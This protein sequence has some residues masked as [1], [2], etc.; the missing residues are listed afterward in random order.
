MDHMGLSLAAHRSQH[1]SNLD[2]KTCDHI[3]CMTSSHAAYIRSMGVAPQQISVVNAEFGGVPDPF[4]G[5][6]ADYINC[7]QVLKQAAQH[8]VAELIGPDKAVTT[9]ISAIDKAIDNAIA[10]L[11]TAHAAEPS[12]PSGKPSELV[13]ANHISKWV[14]RLVPMPSIALQLAARGQH[15]ERW[16]IAR[17]TFP[18]DKPG[19]FAWRKAVQKRQGERAYSIL[20]A[21]GIDEAISKQVATLVAKSAPK[22][23]VEA[24]AL[25]D[26]ACLTFLATE[27]GDF[28]AHHPDYT[29][30]KFIGRDRRP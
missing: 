11:D 7:A 22:G 14:A 18:M 16:V 3:L 21:A 10:A 20:R 15:L 1:V 2:V 8:F 25:E 27:L 29:R 24:Q 19:Y 17:S 6:A 13:Y 28:A 4:G 5:S 9:S 26:A 12:I 23:D 30:E